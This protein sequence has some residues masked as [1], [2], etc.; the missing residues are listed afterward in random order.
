MRVGLTS[1]GR[2]VFG[3]VA[4]ASRREGAVIS[5]STSL[6][7]HKVRVHLLVNSEPDFV[8]VAGRLSEIEA[9][10]ACRLGLGIP[11]GR[12]EKEMLEASS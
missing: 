12:G 3:D 1:E 10:E 7:C 11:L 4:R 5:S 9:R 8:R 2:G 6:G